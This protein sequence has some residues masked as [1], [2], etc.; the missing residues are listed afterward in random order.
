MGVLSQK[1]LQK[2]PVV[3]LPEDPVLIELKVSE[4][5]GKPPFYLKLKKGGKA[6]NILWL[7][8]QV[9]VERMKDA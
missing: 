7:A 5:S 6:F 3:H 2:V 4:G 1:T 8:I 9:A